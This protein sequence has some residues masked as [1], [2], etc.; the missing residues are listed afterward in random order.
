MKELLPG[1]FQLFHLGHH[2]MLSRVI[3][4]NDEIIILVKNADESFHLEIPMTEG[5]RIEMIRN[6]MMKRF[7]ND[8]HRMMIFPIDI[9]TNNAK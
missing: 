8:I 5:E 3:G 1:R 7:R 4:D 9:V 2:H 6:V